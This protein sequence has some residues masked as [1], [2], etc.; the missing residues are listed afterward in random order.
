MTSCAAGTAPS[1][2][3]AIIDELEEHGILL[4]ALAEEVGKDFDAFDLICHVAFDQ[5]PLTRKERAEQGQEA[6]LLHQ[7]RRAGPRRARTRCSTSMPT[8]HEHRD[9]VMR[10]RPGHATVSW[11]QPAIASF[12]EPEHAAR[13]NWRIIN[14]VFG[15]KARAR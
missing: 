11:A 9:I 3:Q 1:E 4:E 13:P 2:K 6:Q 14:N 7:V 8:R 15:G 5:P 10:S 12:T